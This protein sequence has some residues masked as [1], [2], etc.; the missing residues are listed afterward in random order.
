MTLNNYGMSARLIE[1]GEIT[2]ETH[3]VINK[4]GKLINFAPGVPGF[5]LLRCPMSSQ[6]LSLPTP[7]PSH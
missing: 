2:N 3:R 4:Q 5:R 7:T 1:M 6:S